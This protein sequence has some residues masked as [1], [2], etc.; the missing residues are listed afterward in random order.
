MIQ[1]KEGKN[2]KVVTLDYDNS[3][4]ERIIKEIKFD[5]VFK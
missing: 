3:K 1:Y 4:D 2:L 5:G